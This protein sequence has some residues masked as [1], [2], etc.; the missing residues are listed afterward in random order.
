MKDVSTANIIANPCKLY[1]NELPITEKTFLFMTI[2][3]LIV[4]KLHIWKKAN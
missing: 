3:S 2:I 1:N 4:I